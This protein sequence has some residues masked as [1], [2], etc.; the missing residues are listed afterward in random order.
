[1]QGNSP[2]FNDDTTRKLSAYNNSQISN[3]I[4]GSAVALRKG[5]AGMYA[6]LKGH[7]ARIEADGEDGTMEKGENDAIGV[8][9]GKSFVVERA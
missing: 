5:S 2:I 6:G 3:P 8:T 1:M 4:P 9:I 7:S